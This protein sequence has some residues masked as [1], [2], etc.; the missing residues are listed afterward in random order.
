MSNPNRKM[1]NFSKIHLKMGFPVKPEVKQNQSNK[2]S[3][4]STLKSNR[5]HR[6]QYSVKYAKEYFR[7][8][9]HSEV[10]AP[11]PILATA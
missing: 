2:I 1:T 8:L 3:K 11:M 4:E 6:L 7:V 9:R 10:T 5:H